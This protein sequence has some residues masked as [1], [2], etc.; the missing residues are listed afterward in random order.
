[1]VEA[2]RVVSVRGKSAAGASWHM[3]NGQKLSVLTARE[4]SS[5]GGGRWMVEEE[6]LLLSA[7][8]TVDSEGSSVAPSFQIF[9]ELSRP[10]LDGRGETYQST[11]VRFVLKHIRS[12]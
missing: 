6:S 7:G 3:E 11:D 8:R 4:C 2:N 10:C 5:Q 1:M 9:N 12:S